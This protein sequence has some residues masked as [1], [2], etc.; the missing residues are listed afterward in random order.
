M[1]S[2]VS[3]NDMS[4]R[5]SLPAG[6]PRPLVPGS[7]IQTSETRKFLSYVLPLLAKQ[8][9]PGRTGILLSGARGI[10]K[11]ELIRFVEGLLADPAGS[12][13]DILPQSLR[14]Y[15]RPKE[16]LTSLFLAVPK[17][18]EPNLALFLLQK[19]CPLLE[20]E[21]RDSA[22]MSAERFRKLLSAGIQNQPNIPAFLA[23]DDLWRLKNVVKM[24]SYRA[25][26]QILDILQKTLSTKGALTFLVTNDPQ[27]ADIENGEKSLFENIR[28]KDWEHFRLTRNHVI[29]LVANLTQ[30]SHLEATEILSQLHAKLPHFRPKAATFAKIFPI[31]PSTFEA[32]MGMCSHLERF[33]PLHFIEASLESIRRK[34]EGAMVLPH[35][36]FTFCHDSLRE[37]GWLL[38]RFRSYDH[39]TESVLP[40]LPGAVGERAEQLIQTVFLLSL[41]DSMPPT[42]R[43]LS[44][45]TPQWDSQISSYGLNAALM[46]E[47]EEKGADSLQGEGE[48]WNRRYFLSEPGHGLKTQS[49]PDTEISLQF[50]P[51]FYEWLHRSIQDW[52]P[53]IGVWYQKTPQS[54]PVPL[55]DSSSGPEGILHFKGAF[56]PLWA[57]SDIQALKEM[58]RPWAL[59][60]LNPYEPVSDFDTS[61]VELAKLWDRLMIWNPGTPTSKETEALLHVFKNEHGRH[62]Q[63]GLARIQANAPL[64]S[65]H[66]Q[67]ESVLSRLYVERGQMITMADS[68]TIGQDIQDQSLSQYLSHS[69]SALSAPVAHSVS[70]PVRQDHDQMEARRFAL[71]W[72]ILLSGTDP[73]RIGNSTDAVNALM[74]WWNR[75]DEGT[76]I[77][78]L[79]D[80]PP[81]FMTNHFW[82]R[83]RDHEGPLKRIGPLIPRLRDPNDDF[84]EIMLQV[85]RCFGNDERRAQIWRDS[86]DNFASL[87]RWLP[88]FEQARN[89]LFSSTPPAKDELDSMRNTLLNSLD[90]PELFL[91]ASARE[92]FDRKFLEFKY[93]YVDYYYSAHEEALNIVGTE[94]MGARL[95]YVSLRNLERLSNLKNSDQSY[96]NRIRVIGKWVQNNQCQLPVR[97][98]LER[99]PRCFC[100]FNP[101]SSLHASESIKQMSLLIEQ[102]IHYFRTTLRRFAGPIILEVKNLRTDEL[103]SKQI[104][105]LLSRGPMMPLDT[106]AIEIL[107]F[108]IQK[109]SE[110]FPE[111]SQIVTN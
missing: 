30:A 50:P 32:V 89:Y 92:D 40:F 37:C 91:I 52:R 107:N 100:G 90:S 13:W 109:H 65:A 24:E 59:L 18:T 36:L 46:S 22:D 55:P 1:T 94:K 39:L 76:L 15:C 23:L 5:P 17:E 108:A 31:H 82:Q 96:L 43:N 104:A 21:P 85:A 4:P 60:I 6:G 73:S 62:S 58:Q 75:I 70:V 103:R 42:I 98:I 78:R 87:V 54:L 99:E 28:E 86:L 34:P 88:G 77:D 57:E 61:L 53:H 79:H 49:K 2:T 64:E 56:E 45:A 19:L 106:E 105:A 84:A 11:T 71:K 7:F 20:L 33:S 95:D 110:L 111:Q 81:D 101:V 35:H 8:S 26:L 29:D 16:P 72:S 48:G 63:N 93:S 12:N 27:R 3:D 10:G 83:V 14:D 102:G 74:D 41:C 97:K 44:H 47:I 69:L 51:L 67:L 68:W 25:N 66:P 38:D 80:L 9:E